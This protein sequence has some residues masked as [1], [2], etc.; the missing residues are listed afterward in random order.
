MNSENRKKY[1]LGKINSNRE[2]SVKEISEQLNISLPTIRKDFDKL[3]ELGY[4]TR[5]HGGAILDALTSENKSKDQLS[6][7]ERNIKNSKKKETIA[8]LAA[9][10]VSD[11][12]I[13]FLDAGTTVFQMVKH[14]ADKKNIAIITNSLNVATQVMEMSNI[15][16]HL[17]G[18]TVKPISLATV[19]YETIKNIRQY[20]VNKLFMG[21]D[22][23]G[24]DYFTVQ[25]I[26]EAMTKQAMIEI[27]DEKYLLVDSS[28]IGKP[29]LI[30]I[31]KLD[32]LDGII[33]ENG[34]EKIE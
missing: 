33:T 20:Q 7:Y 1:I 23:V 10:L 25:D 27:S 31:A 9:S 18:G 28:K 21:A 19:G 6:F 5:T 13:I 14:L 11:N 30:E 24:N 4:F 22:G 26:N 32:I 12:D 16:H 17:M 3:S 29:T 15:T 8:K 2:V 34:I